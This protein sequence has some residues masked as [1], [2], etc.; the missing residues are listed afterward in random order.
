MMR[1]YR[2]AQT[3][4]DPGEAVNVIRAR[5]LM[6]P[7]GIPDFM[8]RDR[9]VDAG[10]VTVTGKAWAGHG[11]VSRVEVSVDG[12]AT[13]SDAR[14]DKSASPQAW[15]SWTFAWN[16]MPGAYVLQVRASDAKDNVQ[17]AV[18]QWNFGGYGNNGVQ[19]VNVVVR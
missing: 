11:G 12:G 19:R 2:Y 9:L 16:A 18:Q 8:T 4:E 1:A 5:A 10:L 17:P 7:P 13:W 3:A 14:L 15:S 6:I